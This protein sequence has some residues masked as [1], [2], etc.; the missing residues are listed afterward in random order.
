MVSSIRFGGMVSG[1]DT[2]KMVKELMN[3]E[4]A[5]L[6]K[7]K[8]KKQVEEWKRDAYR[9]M[10]STLLDLQKSLNSLRFAS[11]F[12]K[13]KA[14]SENDSV[15]SVKTNG[16]PA[17][18]NYTIK[19]NTLGQ[20]AVP[21]SA[22][23]TP[24]LAN[25]T[26]AFTSD[27]SFNITSGAGSSTIDVTTSDTIDS[28]IRK[29]NQSS[30]GVKATYFNGKLVLNNSDGTTFDL[31]VTK[32]DG[33]ELGL[34]STG[35]IKTATAGVPGTDTEVEINGVIHKIT[36]NTFT[37]DG[38]EITVKQKTTIPIS[39]NVKSDEDA[40]FNTIKD[41]ITKY[42]DV[43]DKVNAKISEK[44]NQGYE[45]LLD[46]DRE[47][48]P[49]KTADKLEEMA[50]SGILQRDSILSSGLDALRNALAIP[51]KGADT[52]F[53]TLSEIGITGAPNSKYAY[54]DKGKLYIDEAKLREAINQNGDK[55]VQ[56]F[57][58]YS[59]TKD[60]NETGLAQRLYDELD[61]SIKLLSAKA[62]STTLPVD[63]SVIGKG[64]AQINTDI[65]RW[66]DRLA[67]I[68]GRYWKK[69]TAME[70]ALSKY[71]S[72]STWFTNLSGGQ[73]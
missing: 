70:T 18:S 54:L 20:A 71:N 21:A 8:R 33:A 65:D 61:K 57:S 55:V 69:F 12:D 53:D 9:D 43:L 17:L 48:L 73:Q 23:L 62:G 2:E 16:K 15:V 5:P 68:E 52:S 59:N 28:V 34:G 25:S 46:E 42:N 56:L 6:N 66:E 72:Q 51:L 26:T 39:I 10:N 45:P 36:G 58:Q 14:F 37:Y 32:G 67:D 63:D 31:E 13:K 19:V 22:E 47:K 44:K 38:M 41:F 27:F 30:S 24:T 11:N 60:F 4:R 3:A 1:L 50:K 35:S 7:L 40:V 29:I 49:E 64:I